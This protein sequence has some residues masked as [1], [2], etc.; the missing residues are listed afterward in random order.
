[1]VYHCLVA[2]REIHSPECSSS[3]LCFLASGLET[4][5]LSSGDYLT[6]NLYLMCE[7]VGDI[8]RVSRL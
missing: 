3:A 8:R 5:G 4:D 1:M 2:V 6:W 7:I